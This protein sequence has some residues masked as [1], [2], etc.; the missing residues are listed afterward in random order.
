MWPLENGV[1]ALVASLRNPAV[2][3]ECYDRR[4]PCRL[5]GRLLGRGDQKRQ[6]AVVCRDPS[7]T[8]PLCAANAANT[9]SFST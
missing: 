7:M 1:A 6:L 8:S 2:A 3:G 5:T 9:W 4:A